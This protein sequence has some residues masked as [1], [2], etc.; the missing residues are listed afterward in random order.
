M[1][2]NSGDNNSGK[3]NSGDNNSG[4]YNS[5]DCN[6]GNYNSG[7]CNSGNYNSGYYNSGY[8][9]SGYYNSGNYNSGNY[10]SGKYNS[11]FFCTETPLAT[12]FDLPTNMTQN[13]AYGLIPKIN[14]LP[15]CCEWICV[16]KMSEEQKA[17]HPDYNSLGGFLLIQDMPFKKAFPIVWAK[18]TEVEK[19]RWLA[20][21]NFNA[22]QFLACTGVDVRGEN[23]SKPL[24]KKEKVCNILEKFGCQKAL[25]EEL[26]T[27]LELT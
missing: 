6:S 1:D 9:N 25:I 8:Y 5:G 4:K 27:T 12:F 3:Y 22:E 19:A 10:N 11:G 26:L 15:V 2:N 23:V 16:E 14:N 13:E 20:L 24:T 7:D 18:M 21:P 17:A